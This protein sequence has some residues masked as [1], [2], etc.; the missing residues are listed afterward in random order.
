MSDQAM[1]IEPDA[2]RAAAE[3][4]RRCGDPLR[5]AARSIRNLP[6]LSGETPVGPALR[7]FATAWA[8]TLDVVGDD[9]V[10]CGARISAAADAWQATDRAAAGGVLATTR[11]PV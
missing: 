11:V 4:I 2:V 1:S 3:Q 5:S 9:A 6:Q 7:E 10:L 8:T